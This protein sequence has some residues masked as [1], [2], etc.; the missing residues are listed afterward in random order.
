MDNPDEIT[1]EQQEHYERLAENTCH[2]K[3]TREQH[4]DVGGYT[5]ADVGACGHCSCPRFRSLT[6]K[7]VR[8]K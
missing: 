1:K 2:C 8:N 6:T 3:H 5:D 7:D 4:N